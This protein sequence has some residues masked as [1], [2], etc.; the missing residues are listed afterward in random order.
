MEYYSATKRNKIGSFVVMWM[1]LDTV[2]QNE[3][4]KKYFIVAYIRNLEKWY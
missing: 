4:R 1:D 2:R 3:V